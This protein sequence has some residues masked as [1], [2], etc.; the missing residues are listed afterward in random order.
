MGGENAAKRRRNYR[1]GLG[2]CKDQ[3]KKNRGGSKFLEQGSFWS[4]ENRSCPYSSA[5]TGKKRIRYR[6]DDTKTTQGE[7]GQIHLLGKT[8]QPMRETVQGK[9]DVTKKCC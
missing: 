1:S 4:G 3:E 7:S 6:G 5:L 2:A 8:K 9:E